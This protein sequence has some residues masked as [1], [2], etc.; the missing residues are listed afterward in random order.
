MLEDTPLPC[1]PL[2]DGH[3][4]IRATQKRKEERGKL[5]VRVYNAARYIGDCVMTCRDEPG[6]GEVAAMTRP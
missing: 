3:R 1:A 5:H 6:D 4:T 2:L